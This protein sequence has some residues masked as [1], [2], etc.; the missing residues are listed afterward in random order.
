MYIYMQHDS[1]TPTKSCSMIHASLNQ[2][3]WCSITNSNWAFL[4]LKT[5]STVSPTTLGDTVDSTKLILS[6]SSPSWQL[7]HQTTTYC[8]VVCSMILLCAVRLSTV[9]SCH[10]PSILFLQFDKHAVY[11]TTVYRL[12]TY[13]V[14]RYSTVSVRV[15]NII[16]LCYII[17]LLSCSVWEW[18]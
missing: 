8:T 1:W 16:T 13:Y 11:S 10:S 4:L 5:Q 6:S 15:C 9:S 18:G 7:K 12:Y 17:W 2:R 3:H 14:C